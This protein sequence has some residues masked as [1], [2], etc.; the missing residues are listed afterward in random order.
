MNTFYISERTRDFTGREWV[1]EKI[2]AWLNNP[3][4]PR[5]F[6]L[7][8]EPG[9]GKSALAARL[10]KEGK[11]QA[12]HFSIARQADTIDPLNFARSL[13]HQLTHLEGFSVYLLEESAH[14]SQPKY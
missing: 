9:A 6:I 2:D 3:E 12:Y 11:P 14:P 4:G 7:T 5:F 10:V 1:L 8:G 13:S